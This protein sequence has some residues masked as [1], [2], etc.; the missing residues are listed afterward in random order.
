VLCCVLLCVLCYVVLCGVLTAFGTCHSPVLFLTTYRYTAW[1]Y[2]FILWSKIK[3]ILFFCVVY[4][5]VIGDGNE[6]FM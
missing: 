5:N 3:N 6:G 1:D 2:P 4:R